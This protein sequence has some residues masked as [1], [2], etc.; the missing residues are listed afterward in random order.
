MKR[1]LVK[2][3]VPT[4]LIVLGLLAFAWAQHA[5]GPRTTDDQPRELPMTLRSQ[6]A[7]PIPLPARDEAAPPSDAAA[8]A[9]RARLAAAEEAVTDEPADESAAPRRRDPFGLRTTGDAAAGSFTERTSPTASAAEP[10]AGE[11]PEPLADEAAPGKSGTTAD[12]STAP[13]EVSESPPAARRRAAAFGKA[14]PAEPT[15]TV[16]VRSSPAPERSS[17]PP[18]AD[19]ST[20]PEELEVRSTVSPRAARSAAPLTDEESA[21]SAGDAD[22]PSGSAEGIGRPGHQ[23]LEGPQVPTLTIE[24]VAPQEIQVG[25]PATF[26]IKVRNSGGIVAHGVEVHDQVPK[27]TRLADTNPKAKLSRGGELVWDLGSLKPGDEQNL[28]MQLMPLSEGEIGSTATVV[29]RAEATVRSVATRPGLDVQVSGPKQA[30]IGDDVELRIKVTNPGSGAATGVTVNEVVPSG[31]KHS[32]GNELEFEIGLLKPGESRDLTLTLSAAAAGTVKNLLRVRGDANLSAE[33]ETELLVVAP[34]LK[35]GMTGPRRRYLDRTATYNISVSNP[36]T[37]PA[38]EV[39][40]VTVLPKGLKFVGANNA[41]TYDAATHS[42]YWSLEELPAQ[43]TGSVTLTAVPI[44]PGDMKVQIKGQ[45]KQGL[46]D[47]KEETILVEGISAVQFE[48][49]DV[50][51]PVEVGG[52]TSYEVRVTNQGSKAAANVQLTA[53]LPPEMQPL[54]AEGPVR[55]SIEG[56]KVIFESLN[57]LAP[58]ADTT[59]TIK[60]KALK[61]GDQRI[62]VQV[63]NDDLK[64]PI[65]KEE[66]TRVFAD[67]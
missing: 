44:E 36:G 62:R 9:G 58:K 63:L 53:I 3:S 29:F 18:V 59:F 64:T 5:S 34:E 37:A 16:K 20:E 42:V 28:Q 43:E 61:D 2:F 49:T 39:E 22:S 40:L 35:V 45:A 56:Q 1:L 19:A 46:A 13:E 17:E 7:R 38:R 57:Q 65:T 11:Q 55:H 60:A 50:N 21:D 10:A 41:G 32:A 25:K 67:E 26:A 33:A 24:K 27:G 4:T 15:T 8:L 54:S 48:L 14:P 52:Q 30:M 51:D 6:M 23:Q 31:L 47:Q 66:S 12:E